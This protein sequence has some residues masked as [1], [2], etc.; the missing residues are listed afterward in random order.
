MKIKDE[1]LEVTASSFIGTK[2]LFFEVEQ[3]FKF[4]EFTLEIEFKQ[5]EE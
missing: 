4:A 3:D 2:K 5:S 1:K